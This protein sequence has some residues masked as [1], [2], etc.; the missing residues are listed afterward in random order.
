MFKKKINLGKESLL[1]SKD[2]KTLIAR[3]DRMGILTKSSKLKQVSVSGSKIKIIYEEK[4]MNWVPVII[5]NKILIPTIYTLWSFPEILPVVYIWPPVSYYVLNFA[6]LMWPGVANPEEVLGNACVGALVAV[7]VIGNVPMAVGVISSLC[8][9]G[10]YKGKCVEILHCYR[11]ELWMMNQVIPNKGFAIDNVKPLQDN[12]VENSE[13]NLISK[14]N[15]VPADK[16]IRSLIENPDILEN[17]EIHTENQ[18]KLDELFDPS[19]TPKDAL[20]STQAIISDSIKSPEIASNETKIPTNPNE[21]SIPTGEILEKKTFSDPIND[22]KSDQSFPEENKESEAH[23]IITQSN[24]DETIMA[25][26]LTALKIG[27]PDSVLPLEPSQLLGIMSRCKRKLEINFHQSSYKKIGKFLT[28]VAEL[29]LIKYE[30]LK[31]S[32]HKMITKINRTHELLTNC[33]PIVSKLKSIQQEPISKDSSYPKIVFSS[34]FIPKQQYSYIF[35]QVLQTVSGIIL[36]KSEVNNILNQ[37]IHQNNLITTKNT[38]NIDIHL[39][40]ALQTQEET[41]EKSKLFQKFRDLFN[42]GYIEEYTSG[43]MPS[44]IRLGKIPCV[45]VS[46]EKSKYKKVLTRVKGSDDYLIDMK[47]FLGISQRT[48]A[49]S[50]ALVEKISGNKTKLEL[51]VQGDHIEKITNILLDTFNVPKTQILVKNNR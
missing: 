6:D 19:D 36:N 20:L 38:V 14:E 2:K 22:V 7:S 47:S 12:S 28:H 18:I 10:N 44:N 42:E 37:Y 31:S 15:E 39:Q 40:K 30:K 46:L 24:P 25:I 5:D 29:N 11:D 26:F 34:G 49:A 17:I 41:I 3:I 32:D 9:P 51:Q 50:A 4:D 13:N 27:A 35:S 33:V 45:T 43:L 23:N 8:V 48:L 1:S 16:N 21:N